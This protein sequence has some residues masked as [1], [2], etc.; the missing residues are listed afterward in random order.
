M[1]RVCIEDG[2]LGYENADP[3]LKTTVFGNQ[4]AAEDYLKAKGYHETS[5][6][7]RSYKG[8]NFTR[9]LGDG[10]RYEAWIEKAKD[11]YLVKSEGPEPNPEAN[12]VGII[13]GAWPFRS[14]KWHL[15]C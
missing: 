11:R 2:L 7:A 8:K 13:K 3:K 12:L 14:L 15:K 1:A 9:D 6:Y 10:N 5:S 4:Q